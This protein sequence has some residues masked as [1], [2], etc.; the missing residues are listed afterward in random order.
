MAF[1]KKTLSWIGIL[2][3]CLLIITTISAYN[4]KKRHMLQFPPNDTY[5]QLWK[6]VEA[7]EGKGLTED[8]LKLTEGIYKKAVSENNAP[9]TV[10]SLMHRMKYAQFKED[11]DVEKNVTTLREEIKKAKF[12]VKPIL[13]SILADAYW[14]YYQNNS[15]KFYERSQT[16][17]FNNN[18]M[19]TWDIKKL[20]YET[21]TAYKAS[22]QNADSLKRTNVELFDEIIQGG[23][24]DT[25]KWRPTLYDFLAHRALEFFK[26]GQADVTK[27]AAQF[28]VNDDVYAKP[29]PEFIKFAIPTPAD[30]LELKYYS[31]NLYKELLHFHKDANNTEALLDLELERYAFIKTYSQNPA[32]DTLYL[33]S[34][35]WLSNKMSNSP[36]V[37]EIK[38]KEA[39][40]YF[41]NSSKYKPFQNEEYKGYRQKAVE[42]CN[43]IV[44][45]HPGS[46]GAAEAFNLLLTVNAK[47]LNIQSEQINEYMLP[48]RVLVS[49]TNVE[50]LYFK[51]FKTTRQELRKLYANYYDEKILAKILAMPEAMS[52]EQELPK[53]A[54]YN[55]HKTE[56]KV[57]AIEHGYYV[58]LAS[59]SPKFTKEKN[60]VAYSSYI[61]SDIA[62]I[63][64]QPK[65]GSQEFYVVSR[66]TGKPLKEAQCQTWTEEYDYNSRDYIMRKAKLYTT[67]ADGFISIPTS[68]NNNYQGFFIEFIN[69]SDKLWSDNNFYSY[70]RQEYNY[71]QTVTHFFTDRA[72]Y[73][74][75]QTIYFKGIVLNNANGKHSILPNYP[76][77]INLYNVNGEVAAFLDLTSNEYGTVSGSFT[78]PQGVLN[79]QMRIDNG[80]GSHYFSVEEYKRPKFEVTFDTLKGSYKLNDKVTVKGFAKAY[81]GNMVDGASVNYRVKRTINYPYW[82]YWY[83]PYF[84]TQEVEITNGIT[85]T[86]EKGEYEIVFS[87]LPDPT[88]NNKDNPTYT[89]EISAD[90]TDINGETH[91]NAISFRVGTQAIQLNVGL[92]EIINV[93]DLPK[94]SYSV[95]NLNGAEE[96][97]NGTSTLYKLKQP[98]KV[99]RKRLWERPDKYVYSKD[100]YYKLFPNDMYAD[101]TNRYTW[102]RESK[103]LERNFN[104]KTDKAVVLNELKNLVPGVYLLESICKD[105]FGAEVKALNYITIYNSA[106]P[107]LPE[108]VAMWHFPFKT[109]AEPGEQVSFILASAY[110]DVSFIYEEEHAAGST[111][112][113]IAATMTPHVINV[114]ESQRGGI[115]YHAHFVK[116]NRMYSLNSYITVPYTN[117][118]LDI[119]FETF[120]NKLLPG[121]KEEWKVSIKNKKGEKVAAELMAAMYDASLDAFRSNSWYMNLY[122]SYYAGSNWSSD[123]ERTMQT[124]E[125]MNYESAYK[126]VINYSYDYLNYFGLHFGYNYYY[127]GGYAADMTTAAPAAEA[128]LE[129]AEAANAPVNGQ[130]LG[131]NKEAL[132]KSR[133]K[134]GFESDE[135]NQSVSQTKDDK[136]L[137]APGSAPK[138]E[139]PLRSNFNETAFFYPSLKTDEKGE[140]TIQFTIPE[141]LTKWKFLSMAHTKDLS[142][143]VMENT[144][145]TQKDLMV[146]PNMPR[147]LREGDQIILT[148]K[149]VNL[150]DK[151]VTGTSQLRLLD[152]L[153]NKDITS[154]CM[155][156]NKDNNRS[157]SAEAKQSAA[158]EWDVTVPDQYQAILYKI[159][160]QAANF[161]DGE[162]AALPV[163]TN[164]MLVT[165]SMPLPIRGNQSKTFTF[166]KFI[167]QNNG[168]KTLKNHALTLEFTANPAWYAVQSLP[169]LMEYPYE[170]AEQTFARYYANSLAKHIAN[171]TP[172][173]KAVFETWKTQSPES[174]LSNLEKNQELKAALLQETPWVMDANNEG[175]RKKRVALLFDLNKMSN[176]LNSAFKK[177]KDMQ[178]ANGGW[179][180]FEGM[181]EDWYITQYIATGMGHLNQLNVIKI[182]EQNEIWNMTTRAVR[183]CDDEI[184][185]EYEEIKR[186]NKNYEKEN[187]L[188]YMA[189]QYLYMRSY[190]KDVPR[191]ARNN[192][193]F[194]Y[195]LKQAET[196]WLTQSR[197][198]QGMIALGLHRYDK[199]TIALGIMKSLKQNAI[200]N[201]EMGMYW[202]GYTGGYYWYDAPIEMQALMVEAFDEVAKD[203]QSVDDLRTW[204]LKSK[205]T[206]NWQST[207][208]TT[209]AVYALLLRGTNWLA[210][211]SAVTIQMGTI[212][213]D[214]KTDKDIKT[215]AG[216]GYFK[217]VWHG[218]DI[219]PEM[220]TVKVEKKDAGVSWG[221]VYWQYFEQLDKI[222]PHETPLKLNKKL[223]IQKN[224]ASGP[225]IEPLTDNTKLK[226]G[227]KLKVRIELRVDRNM[228]Y[229]HMKDMRASGFEPTNVFSG[230]RWQD[231]LGYYESTKDASTNFF[232]S[233]LN[234]GTYVFEYPLVVNH[235][236]NFSNGVTTIQCMYAPEFTSH[237]EGVRVTV[238]K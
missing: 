109:S 77:R 89:Y 232:F 69:G 175:E 151:A 182:R 22:L 124:T 156:R 196:Y 129:E 9:Q 98:T 183:F 83:R 127:K 220:G 3:G 150:S 138:A 139:V 81:A 210:T 119:K 177:L 51:M 11:F 134:D 148:A 205:Q 155:I 161:S 85:K 130:S 225:V 105:K 238:K 20:V 145:I 128:R 206:Q 158:V 8:A 143:G 163:L 40:W 97:A 65:N 101:E 33:Q 122:Q 58:L 30:S 189:I 111:V 185:K 36:R 137:N 207:R 227:D 186:Y 202:K 188:N 217:K 201:E 63:N 84:T 80:H 86:N 78:A 141:S 14:Q 50:K 96:Q 76:T 184:R 146:Q 34:L 121:Q 208:A 18:D 229:V 199:K 190:F 204:L 38:F 74:P 142:V 212:V 152:A 126:Y 235:S 28:N 172:K 226:P 144:C 222:T 4:V 90:V 169:Y 5:E 219:K 216:T 82:W 44:K 35:K 211:E 24:S 120:R 88:A 191:D 180:W 131:K 103:V 192:K 16:V 72:I 160:A 113:K 10:K 94:F 197:Y 171:S 102:E 214:P 53:D 54:D 181:P 165:E 31:L 168:S 68:P 75:G 71:N 104:S 27:A 135:A 132:K 23:S 203:T 140:C 45:A 56:V 57:P 157:F 12:P 123:M 6:R 106:K 149:V 234:K 221:S 174:F 213:V 218:S 125:F 1:S 29:Y 159:T 19:S 136:S 21:I 233:Y 55:P 164:R 13:Q 117:K 215:E 93:N 176:E 37:S 209:E 193:A 17:A 147:F 114:T 32:K 107:E 49:Y 179:P 224:T 7:A 115:V 187:H 91:S 200:V 108:Q 170:C 173:I 52:F 230:Y 43:D 73:R 46:N 110:K 59:T 133:T 26:N 112:E 87:A 62:Y 228:E 67:N 116:H 167:N 166:T 25:R 15:W 66:Q 195:F 42:L 236:G 48:N 154:E 41:D 60:I 47:Q 178:K 237:S 2:L 198:M 223:F 70:S 99:F 162:E 118:E 61:V 194:S 79:G 100:E 64:R 231:G 153:S 92:P 39:Q 95:T